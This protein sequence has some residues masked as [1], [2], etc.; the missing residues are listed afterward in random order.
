MDDLPK[1]INGK[2]KDEER[3]I[4]KQ[5]F[6]NFNKEIDDAWKTHRVISVPDVILREGIKRD[7]AE[8]IT[9]TAVQC[10]F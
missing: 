9:Y 5:R 1:P 2:V 6:S 3:P 4:L 8:H 7:N 10:L